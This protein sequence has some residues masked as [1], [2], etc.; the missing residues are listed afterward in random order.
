MIHPDDLS[1]LLIHRHSVEI[2]HL[3]VG[4][5][6]DGVRNGARI[7]RELSCAKPDDILYALDRPRVHVTAEL[8]HMALAFTM[9][10]LH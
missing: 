2:V 6:P 7:L 4:F 10:V 1:T 9:S 5:W 8:L 3:D